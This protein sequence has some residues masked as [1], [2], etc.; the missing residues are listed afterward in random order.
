MVNSIYDTLTEMSDQDGLAIRKQLIDMGLAQIFDYAWEKHHPAGNF[1][2]VVL[3]TVYTYSWETKLVRIGV[4]WQKTKIK[5]AQKVG[6]PTYLY[7]AIVHLKDQFMSETFQEFLYLY[8]DNMDYVHL[9]SLKELY[10]QVMSQ[11]SRFNTDEA[12]NADLPAKIKNIKQATEIK[13]EIANIEE[14]VTAKY[15]ILNSSKAEFKYDHTEHGNPLKLEN[16][17]LIRG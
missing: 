10:Q 5:I 8:R 16:S 14:E 7:D 9:T 4:D 2:A 17:K 15:R 6:L 1:K 13:T 11:A 3:Y 12:G